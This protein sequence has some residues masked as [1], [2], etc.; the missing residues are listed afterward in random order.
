ML[1]SI[2]VP[3]YKVEKYLPKCIDSLLN[4]DLAES[5]YEIILVD[6]GSPDRCGQICDEY[7]DKYANIR[8]IHQHNGG[9]SAAR[10]AGIKIA[11]GKYI[12]FVDSDDY[13]EPNV[14]GMLLKRMETDQLDILRFNYQNVDEAG[15]VFNPDKYSRQFVNYSDE[16]T[17]GVTFLR[18]RLGTAC[19]ACQ[20]ILKLEL[21]KQSALFTDGLNYEDVEWTPRTVLKAQSESRQLIL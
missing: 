9:L 19:Y 11:R 8:V 16:I 18:E 1:H 5:D 15:N 4:Q 12:Q 3:V 2:I 14:L 13:L 6:D 7:A 10:N 17:D 20:F 21:I